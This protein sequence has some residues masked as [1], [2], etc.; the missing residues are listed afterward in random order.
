MV[1]RFP[2]ISKHVTAAPQNLL[3]FAHV[4]QNIRHGRDACCALGFSDHPEGLVADQDGRHA[5]HFEIIYRA[6]AYSKYVMRM[7]QISYAPTDCKPTPGMN[8]CICEC[9]WVCVVR[10][11]LCV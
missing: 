7:P 2:D 6:D 11:R 10:A 4:L 3:D 8:K 9:V 5:V 1:N